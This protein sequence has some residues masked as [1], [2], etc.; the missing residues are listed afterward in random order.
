MKGPLT[1]SI[2]APQRESLSRM[3]ETYLHHPTFGLLFNLCP[4]GETQGLFTTLY[5]QRLFFRVTINPNPRERTVFESV[6]R[7]EARQLLEE[8][9]RVVRRTGSPEVLR[10]L[11]KV[12]Q[13]TF[14]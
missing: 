1:S 4:L 13:K 8:S 10:S 2:A 11:Q 3:Q 7:T 12:Y 14:F 9:I 6:T 5:A